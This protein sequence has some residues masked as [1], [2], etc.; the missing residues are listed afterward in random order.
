MDRRKAL[1]LCF[2][3]HL[4]PVDEQGRSDDALAT[5]RIG[6]RAL[7]LEDCERS[8]GFGAFGSLTRPSPRGRGRRWW[9]IAYAELALAPDFSEERLG[10]GDLGERRCFGEALESAA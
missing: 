5:G 6:A 7:S 3:E 4:Y 10:G 1:G 8:A 2:G 9:A